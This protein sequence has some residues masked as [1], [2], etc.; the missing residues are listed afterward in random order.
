MTSYTLNFVFPTTSVADFLCLILYRI[1]A[2]F[3]TT[4]KENA[5]HGSS[6]PDHAKKNIDMI[7]GELEFN[8]DGTV[9]GILFIRCCCYAS[10]HVWEENQKATHVTLILF[11]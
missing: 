2:Q 11:L 4:I 7:F 5:V 8:A 10:G 3:G 1:R 6:N 9:K